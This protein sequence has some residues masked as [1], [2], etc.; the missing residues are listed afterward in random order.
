MVRAKRLK[1]SQRLKDYVCVTLVKT[2]SRK[3]R[4]EGGKEGR[5]RGREGRWEG[6]REQGN[7]A[8]SRSWLFVQ[9]I[10]TA[11]N[12]VHYQINILIN[13]LNLKMIKYPDLTSKSKMYYFNVFLFS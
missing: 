9:L 4:K 5:E 8:G 10:F 3:D 11:H 12:I 7:E 13:Y 2:K 6:G 1:I